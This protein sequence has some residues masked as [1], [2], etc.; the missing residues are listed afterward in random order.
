[1]DA[2]APEDYSMELEGTG[3]RADT[4]NRWNDTAPTN[5]VF[6][7]NTHNGV[8]A[9]GSTYI[10][11]LWHDIPGVQK[12]GTYTGNA[13]SSLGP[14]V[15][16]GFRPAL[17]ICRNTGG[18]SDWPVMDDVTNSY[19]PMDAPLFTCY[20]NA[21]TADAGY[22]LDFLSNGFKVRNDQNSYNQNG[23]RYIYMAWA[24]QPEHNLYGGQS[25]AR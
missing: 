24:H 19:N 21:Q 14:Y 16:L 25:N 8:N 9:S 11:Y 18:T 15:E 1:M 17:L 7:V 3:A 4:T 5:S 20:A 23:Y 12:F 13:D 10:A 22:K 2:T 6:T